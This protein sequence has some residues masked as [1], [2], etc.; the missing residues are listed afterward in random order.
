MWG[1][2]GDGFGVWGLVVDGCTARSE[3]YC[4]VVSVEVSSLTHTWNLNLV[5]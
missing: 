4:G 5:F 2:G 3:Q 1:G